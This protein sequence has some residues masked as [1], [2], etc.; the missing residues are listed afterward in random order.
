MIQL[1]L[2]IGKGSRHLRWPGR[3]VLSGR[4]L[5]SWRGRLPYMGVLAILAA[6]A[7]E[8][9]LVEPNRVVL[10]RIEIP[11]WNLP[12]EFDGYRIA[13]LSDLHY[14]R[15]TTRAFIQRAVALANRFSPDLIA[16]PGDICDV[17][18][19]AQGF[20]PS[21]AGLFDGAHTKDGIVAVLGNHD[22]WIDVESVRRELE[23]STPIRLIE[24]TSILLE[25][26][27]AFLAIGGVGDH[28][29]GVVAPER[30]FDGV[31]D[32]VPRLLLSHNPDLADEMTANVRVDLMIS[33]HTHGGQLC[34][35]FGR[36]LSVPSRYGNRFRAGLVQGHCHRVYVSRG[37][38]SAHR[39]R[40]LCPPEV[41]AITLRRS[42]DPR[43]A[44]GGVTTIQPHV[45]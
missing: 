8:T 3:N 26:A 33:G 7:I 15:W 35:P 37:V 31:S 36:A 11:I 44:P 40:F 29:E 17:P 1:R 24:N 30:V 34:L 41:T 4:A 12:P 19:R 22:H 38:A 25:R 16:I 14:P 2:W 21:L 18:M 9:F 43:I 28:W 39:A 20:V 42:E 45:R 6:V 27:G 13:V 5:D 10:E 32:D 23:V